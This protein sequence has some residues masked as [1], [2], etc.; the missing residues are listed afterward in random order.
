MDERVKRVGGNVI[1]SIRQ[2][3]RDLFS[4]LITK[5]YLFCLGLFSLSVSV[6]FVSHASKVIID[7][8]YSLSLMTN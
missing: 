7:K 3:P 4:A 6:L 5:K 8:S 1:E 2:N